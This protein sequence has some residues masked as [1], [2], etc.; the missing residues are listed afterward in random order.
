M[1]TPFLG[2]RMQNDIWRSTLRNV[3]KH[4]G[5]DAPVEQRIVCVD[6]HRQWS[7]AR[8]VI[9]NAGIRTAVYTLTRPF[10]RR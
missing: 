5:V 1:M 7:Q 9:Y 8:N 3:A 2:D 4:W 6:Q 10:R